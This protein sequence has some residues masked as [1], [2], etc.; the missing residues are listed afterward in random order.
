MTS[1]GSSTMP[2]PS[3]NQVGN[4]TIIELAPVAD[5]SLI[6]IEY[7]LT[8]ANAA[9]VDA[10][11][12]SVTADAEF[13]L[14]HG[15]QL[16]FSGGAK[17]TVAIPSNAASPPATGLRDAITVSTTAT[18]IPVAA[19][20]ESIASAETS[21]TYAYRLLLGATEV[22]PSQNLQSVEASDVNSGFGARTVVVSADR[23]V[24]VTGN[25]IENDRCMFEIIDPYLNQDDFI[26]DL[27]YVRVITANGDTYEGPARLSSASSQNPNRAL[28]TYNFEI[29]FQGESGNIPGTYQFTAGDVA[30]FT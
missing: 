27:L 19:L 11:S 30:A 16:T 3:D 4:N 14:R 5:N 8:A 13:V 25:R 29:T 15:A 9:A 20:T 7:T 10:T 26:Q 18:S 6:P 28:R 21:E 17:A 24:S 12:I 23:V 1:S 22:S 2:H